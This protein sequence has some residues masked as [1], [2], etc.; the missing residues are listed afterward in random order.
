MSKF[1]IVCEGI[2]DGYFAEKYGKF[3]KCANGDPV[4]S[5]PIKFFNAPKG[6][7][8]Y[9]VVLEDKDAC[10]VCG[11]SWIHWLACNIRDDME[12]DASR[13]NPPFAQGVNSCIS[14]QGGGKSREE[15]SCYGGMAPPDK[16]HYYEIHAY[17]LDCELSLSD[18]FFMNELY[19]A[20]R[21]HI[22]AETTIGG[23]YRS[24]VR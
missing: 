10:Q 1:G 21:G 8:T 22:I 24:K 23:W 11:F 2:I 20:M 5:P 12:E 3:G 16:D 13:N 6:T 7:V 14:I 15:A 18:G 4:V 17:C 19:H 9:A